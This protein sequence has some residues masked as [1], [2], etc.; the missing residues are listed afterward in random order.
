MPKIFDI[1]THFNVE[2]TKVAEDSATLGFTVINR[3]MDE[4]L[5]AKARLGIDFSLISNPTQKYLD[6]ESACAEYC[7]MVNNTGAE[8]RDENSDKIAFA[9]SLPLPF[10]DAALEELDRAWNEL[11]AS[12]VLLSTN[13]N[14]MYM[15]DE[16]LAPLFDRLNKYNCPILLHPTAPPE[17]PRQPITGQILPMFEFIADTTRTVIDM[18]AAEVFLKNPNL[19]VVVPHTGACL[20]TAIDR[21]MNVLRMVGKNNEFPK[22]QLYFDLACDAFPNAVKILLNITDV[23]HIMYGTDYPAMPVAVLEEHQKNAGEFFMNDM[24]D[25]FWNTA[26][27]VFAKK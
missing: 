27:T 2:T 18:I 25:V 7:R 24:E 22:D 15:G 1:H 26:T 3:S 20:P 10:V 5:E 16:A 6:D 14:G 12:A 13:Y 11:G 23:K 9:A 4:H 8:I 21:A 17:F 19:K